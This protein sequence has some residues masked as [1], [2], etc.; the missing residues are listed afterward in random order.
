VDHDG[1]LYWFCGAGC[2]QAFRADP[3]GFLPS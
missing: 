1:T 2:E 3:A